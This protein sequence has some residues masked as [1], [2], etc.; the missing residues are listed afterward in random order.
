MLALPAF[1]KPLFGR[2]YHVK[3]PGKNEME[4]ATR[5]NENCPVMHDLPTAA[6]AH[7]IEKSLKGNDLVAKGGQEKWLVEF[8]K[9]KMV[10]DIYNI[11]KDG[12]RATSAGREKGGWA[13]NPTTYRF[14]VRLREK[15]FLVSRKINEIRHLDASPLTE[16]RVKKMKLGGAGRPRS[17]F[18]ACKDRGDDVGHRFLFKSTCW[19]KKMAAKSTT[20]NRWST[21]QKLRRL[22]LLQWRIVKEGRGR[23]REK[24]RKKIE[25]SI[26]LCVC[27]GDG[28]AG[29]R[30][31]DLLRKKRIKRP[32]LAD[33]LLVQHLLHKLDSISVLLPHRLEL[34]QFLIHPGRQSS[35]LGHIT[36]KMA[37]TGFLPG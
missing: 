12:M 19:V 7:L 20:M 8:V 11:E 32:C 10:I 33:F 16:S 14:P 30:Q 5:G 1:D 37:K 35:I 3:K 28:P 9:I 23:S 21:K 25:G 15:N 4:M 26:L 27:K 6:G 29:Q 22:T 34:D 17:F 36:T 24:E 2:N 18:V 31:R 13:E